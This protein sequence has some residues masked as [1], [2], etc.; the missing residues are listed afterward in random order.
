MEWRA[1]K[2]AVTRAAGELLA[3][4]L[5][6]QGIAGT[7]I[8]D[9]AMLRRHRD[10]GGWEY[11]DLP[12]GPEV[13]DEVTLTVYVPQE[14]T[15]VTVAA[16]RSCLRALPAA[17]LEPGRGSISIGMIREEDWANAWKAHFKPLAVGEKLL[18][19]P[20][21]EAE[22]PDTG[23]VVVEID[24]GMAFGSGTHPTTELSLCALE[25]YNPAGKIVFDIGTGSG[26]L[27]VA[28]AKLGAAA[29][30]AVDIDPVAVRTAKQNAARNGVSEIIAVRSGDIEAIAPDEKAGIIIANIIADVI[31]AIAGPVRRRLLPGG[32]FIAAGI[33]R[34]RY[35][36]VKAALAEAG[37]IE[38]GRRQ[39][40]EWVA[41]TAA[42]E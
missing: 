42:G 39:A 25:E 38:L 10:E 27:A 4:R 37:F 40:G 18:I 17:G 31:I 7:E 3:V 26:I 9:P 33:I 11:S 20:S 16:V 34:E 8:D 35:P 23:R 14:R 41:I 1:I 5:Q 12:A 29:V 24:P 22:P 21:W 2:V 28:A 15:A 30:V 36:E 19:K 32:V 6:E 13:T